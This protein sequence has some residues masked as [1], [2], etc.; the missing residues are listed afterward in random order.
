MFGFIGEEQDDRS[1]HYWSYSRADQ[2]ADDMEWLCGKELPARCT[3]HPHLYAQTKENDTSIAV[4]YINCSLDEI[5]DAEVKLAREVDNVRFIG[6]KGRQI[7]KRT[8]LI[9]YINANGFAGFE[10]DFAD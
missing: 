7:D 4:G 3:G 6:C 2:I 9:E 8:V 5:F 10:A 1:S